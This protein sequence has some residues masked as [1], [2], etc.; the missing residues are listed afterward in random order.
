MIV[1]HTGI[2]QR[3]MAAVYVTDIINMRM[4]MLKR[5][6]SQ[7]FENPVWVGAAG[8]H[9]DSADGGNSYKCV[10]REI[11]EEIGFD[12]CD[13]TDI[14]LRYITVRY[15]NNEVRHN[16]YFFT[17][18]K[19]IPKILPESN[20]GELK[21][22]PFDEILSLEMPVSATECLTHYLSEGKNTDDIYSC[23]V[24]CSAAANSG[25]TI[26]KLT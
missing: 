14:T 19:N 26:S 3:D 7:L 22:I 15:I 9:F 4:L 13:F 17:E 18:F 20:E 6:G 12:E 11:K 23:A 16:Y 5:I 2:Y 25:S 21:W 24:Y 1:P 10:I 8:G